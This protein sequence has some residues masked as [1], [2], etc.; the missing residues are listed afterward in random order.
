M[1]RNYGSGIQ[2]ASVGGSIADALREALVERQLKARQDMLDSIA[3]EDRER[4]M[5]REDAQDL[6]VKDQDALRLR[7]SHRLEQER[8][9]E[10]RREAAE[11][12]ASM[13]NP[14]A[15]LTPEQAEALRAGGMDPLLDQQAPAMAGMGRFPIAV[16]GRTAFRGTPEQQKAQKKEAERDKLVE[17]Y[18]NATTRQEREAIAFML[19]SQHNI[20]VQAN[21]ADELADYA[22][23]K[24][25]D[26]QYREPDHVNWQLVDTP[27]GVVQV[28]PRTGATRPV[29]ANGQ[30]LTKKSTGAGGGGKLAAGAQEKLA[31][32]S[33]S[34][35]TL[36]ALEADL[37]KVRQSMGPAFGRANQ[38]GL[39]VPGIP[40]DRNFARFSANSATLANA[41]IKAI[42]GAQMSEPEAERI[43]KQIPM[44]TDKPEV[45]EEKAKAT[46]ANLDMLQRRIMQLAN[47]T[48]PNSTPNTTGA[49]GGEN[50][51]PLGVR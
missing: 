36:D 20:T 27:E 3:K 42:T 40:V 18:R 25:I 10:K 4:R 7:E 26:A 12:L 37:P 21:P 44:P 8:A 49:A 13:V 39:G 33:S 16:P 32:V 51:D 17:S 15:E 19:K 29:Q 35:S 28:N 47:V 22:G 11:R 43:M 38:F 48:D 50:N 23:K 2:Y 1:A 45:W 46:R 41:T 5:K 34:L 30:P 6:R 14:G 9:E 31:G 24:K